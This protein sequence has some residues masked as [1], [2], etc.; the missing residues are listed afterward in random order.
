MNT[1]HICKWCT[2]A[3]LVALGAYLALHKSIAA[4]P[5][6][7]GVEQK[8]KCSRAGRFTRPLRKR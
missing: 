2:V 4:Q 1:R 3:A 7:A 6:Q 8:G 5:G